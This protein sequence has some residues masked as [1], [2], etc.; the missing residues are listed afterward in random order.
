MLAT[1]C[2]RCLSLSAEMDTRANPLLRLP[3]RRGLGK[4]LRAGGL[5]LLVACE[6]P[7]MAARA[8]DT[9]CPDP[10][11]KPRVCEGDPVEV[12]VARVLAQCKVCKK[13][14]R[15]R[16]VVVEFGQNGVQQKVA[17]LYDECL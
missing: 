2:D 5:A 12:G 6:F 4:L 8:Q 14:Q 15:Y 3:D 13:R 11:P 7:C 10:K 17:R 16:C 1:F 9:A